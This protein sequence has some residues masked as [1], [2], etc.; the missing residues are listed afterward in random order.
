MG[1]GCAD[2]R[3]EKKNT[4]KAMKALRSRLLPKQKEEDR[5]QYAQ[6]LVGRSYSYN[7][8]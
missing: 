8:F 5:V 1:V 2:E 4:I 3:S 7:M 6:A